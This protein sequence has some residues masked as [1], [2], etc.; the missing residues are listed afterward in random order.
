M[1]LSVAGAVGLQAIARGPDDSAVRHRGSPP[2][3]PD[4]AAADGVVVPGQ[5]V[6]IGANDPGARTPTGGCANGGTFTIEDL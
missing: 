6:V 2:S 1:H 4:L 5:P 3:S